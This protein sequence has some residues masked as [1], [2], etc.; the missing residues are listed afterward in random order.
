VRG[1]AQEAQ[2]A[3]NAQVSAEASAK[4]LQRHVH[5]LQVLYCVGGWVG[6]GVGCVYVCVCVCV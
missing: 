5:Y 2:E 3:R 6:V 4:D 1:L